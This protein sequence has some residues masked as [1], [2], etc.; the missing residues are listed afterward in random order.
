MRMTGLCTAV[1]VPADLLHPNT[2]VP[3][4]LAAH[5][6]VDEI[7]ELH[8]LAAVELGRTH[9]GVIEHD[10]VLVGARQRVRPTLL[11][12]DDGLGPLRSVERG[13]QTRSLVLLIL[14]RNR[15]RE[16]A[17]VRAYGLRPHERRRH[18]DLVSQ[19]VAIPRARSPTACP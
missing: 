3:V 15:A 2:G 11:A 9:A 19:Q 14:Q 16:W 18:H 4:L 13:E 12:A 10:V 1:D 17:G 8:A 6:L 7:E 5:V